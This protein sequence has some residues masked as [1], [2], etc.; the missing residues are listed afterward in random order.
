VEKKLDVALAAAHTAYAG[1]CSIDPC[2]SPRL[3]TL[4]IAASD[5]VSPI[6]IPG[7]Y[8]QPNTHLQVLSVSR[9]LVYALVKFPHVQRKLQQVLEQ[10]LGHGPG[11]LPTLEDR[12]FLPYVE[13]FVREALRWRAP[14]PLGIP[15]SPIQ[16]DHYKG[17]LIPKESS[18]F[19]NVQ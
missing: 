12:P 2:V 18:I 14:V 7:G 1:K 15:H 13:A 17:Y 19:P 3:T 10:H 8:S 16:D 9:A 4:P 6:H 5:T 11:R